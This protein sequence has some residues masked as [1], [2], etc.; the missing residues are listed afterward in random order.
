MSVNSPDW[1]PQ[2]VLNYATYSASARP[3][4][5]APLT[6]GMR[7]LRGLLLIT[8]TIIVFAIVFAITAI[9][10]WVAG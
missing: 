6:P 4:E 9:R 3:D 2:P 7:V 1:P 8:A 5:L 10:M